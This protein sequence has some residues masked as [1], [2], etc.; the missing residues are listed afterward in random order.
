MSTSQS[1]SIESI[2]KS[3]LSVG[4]AAMAPREWKINSAL[5]FFRRVNAT[6]ICMTDDHNA[7]EKYSFPALYMRDILD[8][9]RILREGR[10][11]PLAPP[12]GY[13]NIAELYNA[14][15]V[16][17]KLAIMMPGDGD[18][19]V[20]EAKGPSPSIGDFEV[21]LSDVYSPDV[22]MNIL[23]NGSRVYNKSEVALFDR[24]LMTNA[25]RN[26]AYEQ[27]QL[28]KKS[29]EASAKRELTEEEKEEKAK[30]LRFNKKPRNDEREPPSGPRGYRFRENYRPRE[31]DGRRSPGPSN[32]RYRDEE[33]ERERPKPEA[34]GTVDEKAATAAMDVDDNSKA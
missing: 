30:N 31:R 12:I 4:V 23:G 13:E 27:R 1:L 21:E 22:L 5:R 24:I 16:E 6:T 8:H 15:A 18:D 26:D 17:T 28:E 29:A 19:K 34:S 7:D 11:L 25:L 32:Y 20:V 3:P 14:E 9:D 10:F 2:S 33:R